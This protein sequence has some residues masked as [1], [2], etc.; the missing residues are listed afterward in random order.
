MNGAKIVA[1]GGR[2]GN[3]ITSAIGH[4]FRITSRAGVEPP[5]RPRSVTHCKYPIV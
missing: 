4:D 1:P 5:A 2:S 3:V